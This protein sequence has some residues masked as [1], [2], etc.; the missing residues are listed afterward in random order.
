[1]GG[2]VADQT[3][4]WEL[5]VLPTAARVTA[6]S[7]TAGLA[8]IAVAALQDLLQTAL[9]GPAGGGGNLVASMP[10]GG[11]VGLQGGGMGGGGLSA[12]VPAPAPVPSKPVDLL[13]GLF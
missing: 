4:L 8:P 11:L 3:I 13:D 1:M 12:S 7:P 9:G 6:K 5:H 10:S 2:S